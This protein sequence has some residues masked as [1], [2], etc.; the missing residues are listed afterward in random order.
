MGLSRLDNFLKNI[1]GE[2][3]YV[4]P[5][6]L[7]STDSIENQGNS[8]AR[9]FKTIQRALVEA[10]RFS[11]QKGFNNDRFGKTTILLYPGEHVI[12]NRPGWIPTG[13]NTFLQRSSDVSS[14][15]SPFSGTTDFN[16]ESSNNQLY[17][18][19]S[20]HGG[21][22][23]PRGTSI[24]GLDLRK[25]KI[26]PKYVPD[27]EN[28]NIQRS[29]IFRLT[30]SSYIWQF[31]I[32]DGNP[33]SNVYKDYTGNL[34]IPNFS[35][36][37]LT[38]FEYADGTNSVDISDDFISYSTSRTDLDMYYEK[39]GLAYGPSSGRTIS[40]DYPSAAID[41]QTKID[42]Y[43]IVGSTGAESAIATIFAGDGIDSTQTITVELE[44]PIN[45]LDVDTP[46]Q[47][48]NVTTGG[49]SGQ[50]VVSEVLNETTIK[51]QVQN[52][53]LV[54]SPSEAQIANS[55]IVLV[56][57]TV[58]SASPYIFNIS[59]RSVF[60]MCGLHADGSKTSGFKSM[61]VAQYTGI[62][63]Q[64]DDNAFILYD[65]ETGAYRDRQTVANLYSNSKAIYKPEY[66][67]YHI[68]AS[69]NSF[70][71]IVSVFAIGY[72]NHFLSES[73]GDL[74]ITNSNSNFGAKALVAN[75]YRAKAF[76]Q[77]DYG[78]ITHVI[79]PREH[80]SEEIAIEYAQIDIET[81]NSAANS[82][83]LYL[84]NQ[85][86]QD[87]PPE[88]VIDGYR[89]G[90]K[91]GETLNVFLTKNNTTQNYS[92]PVIMSG[93]LGEYISEKKFVIS[94]KSNQVSN[95]ITNS[96]ITFTQPHSFVTG[97]TVRVSSDSGHLPEGLTNNKIYYVIAN[98][99]ATGIGS[100]QIKLAQSFNEAR[101]DQATT[102]YSNE[103]SEVS[104][105]SRVS[106]KKCGDLGHPIQYDTSRN[107]WYIQVSSAENQ[108]SAAISDIAIKATPRTYFTRRPDVR[109]F[110]DS[111]YRLRYV[112]PRGF[113]QARVPMDG[114]VIQES[115]TTIA[116]TDAE[117]QKYLSLENQQLNS[118]YEIRNFKIIAN[119]T[120]NN[121]I[122]TIDTE[123]PHGLIPGTEVTLKNIRS[124]TN[125]SG[126][127]N[128]GYN[129]TFTVLSTP[130]RKRFVVALTTNPGTFSSQVSVRNTN[131]P[132]LI[133]EKYSKTYVIY[134]T[135][136]I[137]K[138][139][140]GEQ[141]GVY[142]LV[143]LNSSN[144][145]NAAPFEDYNLLQ[146]IQYLYPQTNRDNILSDPISSKSFASPSIIGEVLI[147]DP[148][149]SIT[150]ETV[151]QNITDTGVGLRLENI[152]SDVVGQTHEIHTLQDHGLNRITK[153]SIVNSGQNYGSGIGISEVF[154]NARL[155]GL[156]TTV[157]GD[158]ATAI[159]R[160]N[161][162]TG[163]LLDI[164]I[165]DGGSAY[166]IGNTLAVVGIA[167]T[168]NHS[169]GFVRVDS[170]YN[171]VGDTVSVSG[172]IP[173]TI[174]QYNTVY[175]ITNV[176]IGQ[177]NRFQVS[178]A[179]SIQPIRPGVG[180]GLTS[181]QNA[182]I[183]VGEPSIGISN[184]QYNNTTGIATYTTSANHG[185][186]INNK[187]AIGGATLS[188]FNGNFVIKK[189]ANKTSFEV[190]IG[191]ST[192]AS[193]P[194]GSIFAY[195]ERLTSNGGAV[196]RGNENLS[197]RL[198]PHYAG[199]TTTLIGPVTGPEIES[200]LINNPT[201][202]GLEIGDYLLID[203]EVVRISNTVVGNQIDVFRGVL[204][205]L[206][207]EHTVG[208]KVTRIKPI[209][210]ELRRNSIIRASGH[211][212]EYLGFGPGNY[213]TA[214]P[215][216][217]DRKLSPSEEILSSAFKLNG[218][219]V[220]FTGMNSDGAFYVGNKKITSSTGQEEVF[221]APIPTKTGEDL[222][223]EGLNVG[224]DVLT[225][226]EVTINRSLKVEGG[227]DRTIISE[228]QSPVIFT[229]KITSTSDK[230]IEAQSL[231]LQGNQLTSKKYTVGISAP[232]EIGSPGDVV[233]NA[234]PLS[235]GSIGWV[236]TTNN[237][238]EKFG[239]IQYGD[240]YVGIWSGS[241]VG[242]GSGLFNVSDVW[243]RDAISGIVTTTNV[244]IGTTIS[245]P[246]TA[247]YVNGNVRVDGISTFTNSTQSIS[248]TTGSVVV[249]GGAAIQRNL[250]V[251]Q[252]FSV[253]GVA[254]LSGLV[255]T[256]YARITG[257][258]TFTN[259]VTFDDNVTI[260]NL[261]VT[262]ITTIGTN[263]YIKKQSIRSYVNSVSIIFGL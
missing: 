148:E 99:V 105:I 208:S 132:H 217:Q 221:N 74:S 251:G 254:T 28:V 67:N 69:N 62:G 183:L 246:N 65:P 190:K 228:F 170:I 49:Y 19:N 171:N 152:I 173:D 178:S 26:R 210:V 255:V 58:T 242:D 175:R 200:I 214:L 202:L 236:Y 227:E 127:D 163:G 46:I 103:T 25:T 263:L 229:N 17:K 182:F 3:L 237:V 206:K 125:T 230:G 187:V 112:I 188:R 150:K 179:S 119:A 205:T 189:I 225:P 15:F 257:I 250:N 149:K 95:N 4:D 262:G 138:Y 259:D 129:G 8:L 43:R 31:T 155:V 80:E 10:S 59:L 53:P 14:D 20:V 213:S 88:N 107:Q 240:R 93:G 176:S 50:Y 92:A 231:F 51:Y 55:S 91:R 241:F 218:G 128:V 161:S 141:D 60:G 147:N 64:K 61:V 90:A 168:T 252:D 133:R 212:F 151:L 70:I 23:V 85:T 192:N 37:K 22:I 261:N 27:P 83:R 260:R 162:S 156:G 33:N 165:I 89:I 196:A 154:Y 114:Y 13:T 144:R 130:T 185:F 2:I 115:N 199:I 209:P 57:D 177:T 102:V 184:I 77:D 167:T 7:D 87:T 113:L 239:P 142:H 73:G 174:N 166:G 48:Q 233:F 135:Q 75:G 186:L 198:I 160:I 72:A 134:R 16:L 42:E 66:E 71:Q 11:Y 1:K 256:N 21:V 40:P 82:S 193:L 143:V 96:I 126:L 79:P 98:D 109:S 97:E 68:K 157:V 203:S 121:Q 219:V 120:W 44:E 245:K 253:V 63:L 244:G 5:S 232:I 118:T 140:P 258:S 6:S 194:V 12:D 54:P 34:F 110:T 220:V 131:L 123:L 159:V 226:L 35:H 201:V 223:L 234:I 197:G 215:E 172:V 47:I 139:I 108:I 146:P 243:D 216:R 122:A 124:A 111:I 84:Y 56:S 45:G 52:P 137:Q 104:F 153:L 180:I 164:K 78:F 18:L 145:P 211:T 106:D 204:G 222:N 100:T 32:L 195:R 169:L 116:E 247:L 81:T 86:N 158:N 224:F 238:W 248:T 36:H 30:G 38:V 136:E 235:G 9:P 207:Q 181:T 249:Q 94:K 76:A 24:I 101:I 117:I 29:A 191:V 39:I 41:I